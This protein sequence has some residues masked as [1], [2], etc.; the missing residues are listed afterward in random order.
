[1]LSR[2]D[3]ELET[4]GIALY[5]AEMKGPVKDRLRAYGLF[6]IFD[7][8]HFFETVADAVRSYTAQHR[9]DWPGE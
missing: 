2:L 5:F 6:E 4:A 8:T 3:H 7:D 1:M 9:V